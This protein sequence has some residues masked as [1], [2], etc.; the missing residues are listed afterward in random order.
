MLQVQRDGEWEAAAF[1]SR[2][3]HGAEQRYSATEL[4]ALALVATVGHFNYYL[5]GKPF[6]FF[7]DHRP[8]QQLLTSDKLNPRLRHMAYKLQHW[9]IEIRYIPG[10]KNTF[11]D[12]LSREERKSEETPEMSPDVCLVEGNVEGQPPH[13]DE[14]ERQQSQEDNLSGKP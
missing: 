14:E 7:T 6:I 12:A 13:K 10:D 8:L 1:F 9:M 2:Q 4:D 11:A 3:L 5:Y